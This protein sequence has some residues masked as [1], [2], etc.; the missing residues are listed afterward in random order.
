MQLL[1]ENR[2]KG[3]TEM[4]S[5]TVTCAPMLSSPCFDSARRPLRLCAAR[6][7]KKG[8]VGKDS[9]GTLEQNEL[10]E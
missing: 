2:G 6:M 5:N 4:L 10:R 7:R 3:K 8:M 1:A 9:R